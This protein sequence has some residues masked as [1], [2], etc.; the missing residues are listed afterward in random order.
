MR[1]IFILPSLHLLTMLDPIISRETVVI[2]DEAYDVLH[3]CRALIDYSTVYIKTLRDR[4]S[5]A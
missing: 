2:F 5:G 3:E 4:W 1:V